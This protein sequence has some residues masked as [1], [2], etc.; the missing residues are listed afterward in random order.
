MDEQNEV[1]LTREQ[2][3]EKVWSTPVQKL[4]KTYGLSD[5]GL[6]K[7]C[8][9]H[10]I[11]R[12]PLG[13]WARVQHGYKERKPNL[14]PMA[15][16]ENY[17]IRIFRTESFSIFSSPRPEFIS[18]LAAEK[19]SVPISVPEEVPLHPV[20]KKTTKA[21][22]SRDCKPDQF[23]L[24]KR[25]GPDLLDI[26]VSR[27]SLDRAGRIMTTILNAFERRSFPFK[28]VRKEKGCHTLVRVLEEDVRIWIKEET[29]REE[30]RLTNAEKWEL[31]RSP[32]AYI[33]D[34]YRFSTTGN[35]SLCLDGD[36]LPRGS[37]K[38]WSDSD[39][40]RLETRLDSFFRGLIK[41]AE[42]IKVGRERHEKLIKERQEESLRYHEQLELQ[43]QEE[44]R[45][46][47]LGREVEAWHQS[48]RIR[49]YIATVEADALKRHGKIDSGSQLE[50]WLEWAKRYADLLDPLVP[51]VP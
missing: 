1:I 8:K 34:R 2:L 31:E 23:G 22:R 19:A 32:F 27:I 5:V 4:A 38:S 13:Y 43:R 9:K 30:R 15:Q 14:P 36:F 21:L 44:E 39:K 12:P 48:H 16:G 40:Q 33:R 42:A 49:E 41:A 11:P 18:A 46:K 51:N 26:L 47:V 3:Y 6:A 17:N 28:I 35:L 25:V 50:K 10:R 29:K 7:I 37:R 24:L 20:V 45:R